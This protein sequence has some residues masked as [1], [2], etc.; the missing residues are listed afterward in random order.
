MDTLQ[1]IAIGSGLA[2][3]SGVRLYAVVFFAGL[4]ARVGAIALPGQLGVLSHPLVI[5]VAGFM[6]FIEFFADKIPG[7]DSVW[8]AVHTF[9]RV[10]AGAL[11][12]AA[13]L[14][15]SSDPA[16]VFAAG[17]AGGT[18]AG[19]AHFAKAG[20]RALINSSPE[21][22]SNWAASFGEEAMV[23]SGMWLAF[24]HP[25]LFLVALGL[26]MVASIWLIV[27]LWRFLAGLFRKH[28]LNPSH[29]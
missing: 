27:T 11:L 29:A 9:V 15:M 7:V 10:P 3:A 12:A 24:T 6:F 18:L 1:T 26:V 5:G 16:L 19:T 28:S 8:D 2:W 25:A 13:S 21:P 14:G 4:L 20:S 23:A 22:F 17:L